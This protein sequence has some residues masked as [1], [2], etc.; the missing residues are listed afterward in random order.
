MK[1]P[2]DF[3]LKPAHTE[4]EYQ[5]L[6][7]EHQKTLSLAAGYSLRVR[8]LESTLE[9]IANG[10]G[11][12]GLAETERL[13]EIA[14]AALPQSKTPPHLRGPVIQAHADTNGVPPQSE[15][16]CDCRPKAALH[17]AHYPGCPQADR[18][19]AK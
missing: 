5:A 7:A 15:T 14:R 19:A 11:A 18:G 6:M 10:E 13:Q 16:N 3:M 2:N 12:G 17:G 9:A 8:E 4:A 1:D